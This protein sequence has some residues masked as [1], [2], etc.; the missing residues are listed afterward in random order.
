MLSSHFFSQWF[1]LLRERFHQPALCFPQHKFHKGREFDERRREAAPRLAGTKTE[2][3]VV[4]Q[5]AAAI[6]K[7]TAA[8]AVEAGLCRDAILGLARQINPEIMGFEQAIKELDYAV[9]IALDVIVESERAAHREGIAGEVLLRAAE[10]AKRSEFDTAS[11]IVDEAL[12]ALGGKQTE[13]HSSRQALRQALLEAGAGLGLLRRDPAA[14]AKRIEALAAMDAAETSPVWSAKYKESQDAFYEE[15]EAKGIC[16][17]LEA[18]I[19]M[20]RRMAASAG[21]A[22]QRGTA[23]NLLGNALTRLGE[24]ESGTGRLEEAVCAY[25]EAQKEWTAACTPHQWAA[26]Q[27]NLGN[28]LTRLGEREGGTDRLEEALAAFRESLAAQTRAQEPLRRGETQANLGAAL[29]TLGERQASKERLEEA[30]DACREALEELTPGARGASGL[31]RRVPLP[32]LLRA[33]V[34]AKAGRRGSRKQSRP[35]VRR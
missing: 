23:L 14:V 2:H 27:N 20:A 5:L 6:G 8:M 31:R 26:V 35:T 32:T 11:R 33:L 22:G 16:L 18:A 21:G 30:A 24:C 3:Q 9:G 29:A 4:E 17:P 12:D 25:R 7:D 34:R 15:G 13:P 10:A 28:A 19:E 1:E